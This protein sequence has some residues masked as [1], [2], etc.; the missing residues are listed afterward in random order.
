M[1]IFKLLSCK[2]PKLYAGQYIWNQMSTNGLSKCERNNWIAKDTKM[3]SFGQR[4]IATFMKCVR[5]YA[6]K[7][8]PISI[9]RIYCRS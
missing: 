6:Y 5:L 1:F 2:Y 3:H 7:Y 9:V 4:V 8:M